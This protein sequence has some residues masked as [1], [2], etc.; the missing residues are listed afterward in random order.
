M[1]PGSEQGE[2]ANLLKD[3][4]AIPRALRVRRAGVDQ[5]E[6]NDAIVTIVTTRKIFLR[7]AALQDDGNTT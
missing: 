2:Q 7:P 4:K 5:V 1:P 3:Q 6:S